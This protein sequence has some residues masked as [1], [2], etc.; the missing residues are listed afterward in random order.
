MKAEKL[1]DQVCAA[2]GA[3]IDD[4]IKIGT[5]ILEHPELGFKEV[6]TAG[7]VRETFG[8]LGVRYRDGLAI[9]GVKAAL[10]GGSPGPSVALLAELDGLV[11]P[12]FPQADR[13]TGAAHPC[14]HNVQVAV[15]LGVA[16]GLVEAGVMGELSGQ[17]VLFAVPAEEFVD[18]EGRL[19]LKAEGRIEFLSGKA[20][21]IR[22]GE[23]DDLDMAMV[24]HAASNLPERKFIEGITSNGFIGK[25]IRFSGR[26]AH[27]GGAPYEGINALNAACLAIMNINAQRETFKDEDYVRVHS[28]ITKGGEM[29]NVVPNDVVLEAHVRARTLPAMKDANEKVNRCLKAAA[30]AVNAGVEIVDLP[31]DLP[32]INNPGLSF[33]FRDNVASLLGAKNI[34][35]VVHK[36]VSTDMGDVTHLMPGIHPQ[37]GG[38]T[39]S[40]HTRD[41][42]VADPEMAY[43]I[44]AQAIAMTIIDLL[45]NGA[46]KAKEILA[47]FQPAMTKEDYLKYMRGV[48]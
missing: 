17:V 12:D 13:V 25:S 9:T 45:G 27:A 42:R 3:K 29:V 34:L 19:K 10:P 16:M 8:A 48:A 46:R 5:D 35:P 20:E 38:F 39:G 40:V 32:L 41:F 14:G 33:V 1:K 26:A 7:V 11:L 4:I 36:G 30:M 15:M 6:R 28:I 47:D 2:I 24:V 21:L 37:A 18:I 22:L 44:T 23:F 31:G 43:V